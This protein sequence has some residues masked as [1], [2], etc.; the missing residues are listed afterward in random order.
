MPPNSEEMEFER[1]YFILFLL[2]F[3]FGQD[4]ALLVESAGGAEDAINKWP[5]QNL[6]LRHY[7]GW[8]RG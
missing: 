1:Q 8:G 4:A 5:A 2:S 6:E 3:E 7:L